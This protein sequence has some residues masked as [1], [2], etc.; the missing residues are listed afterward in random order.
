MRKKRLAIFASGTGSNAMNLINYFKDHAGIEVAFV[1]CNNSE[2]KIVESAKSEGVDV[3]VFSNNQVADG[4]FLTQTCHESKIDWIVLA[5][6]L[7]LV[8]SELIKSYPNK[9]INLHP[10]LLPKYGGKGMHGTNVHRAVL[11]NNES[12]SGITI[13][14]VNEKFDDGEI[15]AQFKCDLSSKDT[16]QQLQEKIHTLE[17]INLPVVVEKTMQ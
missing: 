15:I 17:Q 12:K 1:L 4:D 10:A 3:L 8:P 2:A 11:A 14:Y 16:I 13:H 7:R 9:I 6:Y 5:G